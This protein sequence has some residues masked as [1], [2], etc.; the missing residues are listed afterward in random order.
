[1]L[2][3]LQSPPPRQPGPLLKRSLRNAR[4]GQYVVI[5]LVVFI[6]GG[7]DAGALYARSQGAP[8]M[9]NLYAL[10][11]VLVAA[12]LIVVSWLFQTRPV[13]QVVRALYRDGLAFEARVQ[14]I[15]R[16]SRRKVA[17]AVFKYDSQEFVVAADMASI[18]VQEGDACQALYDPKT[19]LGCI[20]WNDKYLVT[21]MTPEQRIAQK[22]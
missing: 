5:F 2:A 15:S 1:M 16:T 19:G 21:T 4:A 14:S 12:G 22:S 10:G 6:V 18:K 20:V 9:S 7:I 13:T 11:T 17:R 8:G 3:E